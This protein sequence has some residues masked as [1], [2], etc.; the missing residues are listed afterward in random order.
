MRKLKKL[1]RHPGIFFRDY[2]NKQYPIIRNEI[3]CPQDEEAILLKHDLALESL[4]DNTLEIDVVFTWVNG[5]DPQWQARRTKTLASHSPEHLGLYANDPARFNNHDELRYSLNS[6]QTYLP[7][8]RRIYIVTDQQ[9]PEWLTP[10]NRVRVIDH[11]ELISP[12]YLPTFNSH[13]IEAHLHRIPE[14]SEHFI[15]FNDDVFVARPLPPGHFFR[16]NGIASLFLSHKSLKAMWARGI[17]TPTLHAAT[18]CAALLEMSFGLK[19]DT[20]LIH[21]YIPLRKSAFEESWHR[22]NYRILQFLN[23]RFRQNNDLNLATFLVPWLMYTQAQASPARDI[24]Y[25]F[26]ISSASANSF[27]LDL[28]KRKGTPCSPHSFCANDFN[29]QTNKHKQHLAIKQY[30]QS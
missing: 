17:S 25:Y 30:W 20:P 14:L 11:Q 5:D 15:Y 24:C 29:S 7:W 19:I 16:S 13:V 8:V 3:A 12:C 2:L 10:N 26:N 6:V 23:N 1:L 21:S 28:K 27:W 4:L 9:C 18:Q 22:F